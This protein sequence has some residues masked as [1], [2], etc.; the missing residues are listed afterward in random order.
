[1]RLRTLTRRAPRSMSSHRRAI[2]SPIRSPVCGGEPDEEAPALG[3]LLDD[4]GELLLGERPLRV[5]RLLARRPAAGQPDAGAGVA[6][7]EAVLGGGRKQRPQWRDHHAHRG[8]REPAVGEVAGERPDVARLDLGEPAAAEERD[9]VVLEVLAVLL[10][11]GRADAPPGAALV[12]PHPLAGV[13]VEADVGELAVVAA[14]D[15]GGKRGLQGPG[16]GHRRGGALAPPP[17]GVGVADRVPPAAAVDP[18]DRGAL[19]GC[20]HRQTMI[21][22]WVTPWQAAQVEF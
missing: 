22:L 18:G 5:A 4:A 16:L 9:R 20:G 21:T 13:V 14:G 15:V 11:R 10:E 1:M 8:R 6:A 19:E 2:S 7:D 3:R 12:G 17:R